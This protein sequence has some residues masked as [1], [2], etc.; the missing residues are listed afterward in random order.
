MDLRQDR[1]QKDDSHCGT[2]K[3]IW[4]LTRKVVEVTLSLLYEG[5]MSGTL[6]GSPV[7]ALTFNADFIS[8]MSL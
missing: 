1:L 5:S 3:V 4:L 2:F 6:A 7:Q 8:D